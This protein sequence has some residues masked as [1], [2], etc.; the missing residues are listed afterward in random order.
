IT[1]ISLRSV[2]RRCASP[3]AVLLEALDSITLRA[4]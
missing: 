2:C 1:L 3:N 4:P